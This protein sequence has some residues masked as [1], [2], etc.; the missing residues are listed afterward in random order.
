ME[1]D[2]N[3]TSPQGENDE[4]NDENQCTNIESDPDTVADGISMFNEF[5][6][7]AE[8]KEKSKS[9]KEDEDKRDEG[10]I[11]NPFLRPVRMPR[12]AIVGATVPTRRLQTIL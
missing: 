4:L 2:D 8:H 7:S 1:T 10:A 3:P 9:K 6:G 5:E 11:N 12:N